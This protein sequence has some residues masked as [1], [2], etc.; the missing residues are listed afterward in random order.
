MSS[1]ICRTGC[2]VQQTFDKSLHGGGEVLQ[3]ELLAY[4]FSLKVYYPCIQFLVICYFSFQESCLSIQFSFPL[5]Q[6][7]T[8]LS[9]CLAGNLSQHEEVES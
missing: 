3:E 4:H 8:L 7:D 2:H 9:K 1:S 6:L 5:L